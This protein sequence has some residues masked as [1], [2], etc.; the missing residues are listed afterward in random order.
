MRLLEPGSE[1]DYQK[2][3]EHE[4]EGEGT[5]ET[6]NSRHAKALLLNIGVPTGHLTPRS[7]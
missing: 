3:E 5:A 6:R 2:D 1:D 4:N 7:L